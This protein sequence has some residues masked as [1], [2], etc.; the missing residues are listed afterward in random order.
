MG[1]NTT[2]SQH[3]A[4]HTNQKVT[5]RQRLRS[6]ASVKALPGVLPLLPQHCLG[7]RTLQ[8]DRTPAL[9]RRKPA[10]LGPDV[11]LNEDQD[12]IRLGNAPENLAVLRHMAMNILQKDK[13]KGSLRGKIV[14][15]QVG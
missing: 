9:G 4:P 3:K 10:A 6:I 7:T 1:G 8:P 12:R 2:T 15:A 11:I 13:E 5:P 14:T